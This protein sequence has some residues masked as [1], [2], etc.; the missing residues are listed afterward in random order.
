VL[1]E[2]STV[3]DTPDDLI[4]DLHAGLLWGQHPYGYNILGT[5][6]SVSRLTADD[7]RRTHTHRYRRGNL[8]IAA[9]GNVQHEQFVARVADVFAAASPGGRNGTTPEPSAAAPR[10]ERM[11]RASAQTHVVFGARTFG[12]GDPRRY[13]LVL[14][15]SAF[16]GG[17]SSRLF[18]RVR[19]ELGLAYAVYSFQSFYRLAG[20]SGVY[21]GTRPE[22]ADRAED[23]IREELA[24]IAADGLTVDELADAKGQVKGQIVLSLESSS[25]RLHRLAGTAL[26]D[27]PFRTME[28]T[29]RCVDA[30][31][32]EE[33]AALAADYFAPDGQTVLRLGPET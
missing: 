9:A 13:A 16:G 2:I 19:E 32:D 24:R 21:V 26:Y 7:L 15:S 8:V 31:T 23:T 3:E 14:L 20:M 17:M 1:E 11:E 10:V 4:F 33:I 22:W 6:E 28:E 25:A 5:R 27:E 12:H 18:Q 29:M 30:V